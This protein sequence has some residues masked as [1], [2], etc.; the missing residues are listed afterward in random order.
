MCAD[1][2]YDYDEQKSK[3]IEYHSFKNIA[4]YVRNKAFY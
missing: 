1:Y 2:L 3:E 4:G